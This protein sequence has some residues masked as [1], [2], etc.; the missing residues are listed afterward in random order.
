MDAVVGCE[1]TTD[2]YETS[3]KQTHTDLFKWAA[4]HGL[5]A[6]WAPAYMHTHGLLVTV[7][8]G[9]RLHGA[10]ATPSHFEVA[11]IEA[12]PLEEMAARTGGA[13]FYNAKDLAD[14]K[15]I[16][17]EGGLGLALALFVFV[18]GGSEPKGGPCLVE[19]YA[20]T[21]RRDP[22][23]AR[24]TS[25]RELEDTVKVQINGVALP[26]L[27]LRPDAVERPVVDGMGRVFLQ[28]FGVYFK[29]S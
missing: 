25:W 18:Q 15:R 5:Q 2:G 21:E 4:V 3:D 27:V 8:F 28:H 22:G 14:C 29:S 16:Q 19:R 9:D 23:Y 12:L 6:H 17:D 7:F 20:L 26:P 24:V 1:P 13:T 11:K 10:G